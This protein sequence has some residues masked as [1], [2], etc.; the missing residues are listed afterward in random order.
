M[1]WYIMFVEPMVNTGWLRE[2]VGISIELVRQKTCGC[3]HCVIAQLRA[4]FVENS[5]QNSLGQATMF[6]QLLNIAH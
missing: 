1:V 5:K 4:V 3:L 2:R 6:E